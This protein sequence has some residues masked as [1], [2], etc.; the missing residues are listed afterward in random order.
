[1]R[2]V[3]QA[4]KRDLNEAQIVEALEACG[5][6][7]QRISAK[8]FP[9]L[10]CWHPRKSFRLVEVKSPKGKAT[11]AQLEAQADGWPVVTVRTVDEAA[12]LK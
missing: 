10:V 2:R 12:N 9:D 8:G 1:M 3:G 6:L 7:V 4:R 11:E 5:W